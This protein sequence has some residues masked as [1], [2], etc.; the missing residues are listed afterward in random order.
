MSPQ[1]W[2]TNSIP[3]ISKLL[4][5]PWLLISSEL[6]QS[7]VSWKEAGRILFSTLDTVNCRVLS[8]ALFSLP[9][10]LFCVDN[11][12]RIYIL[13]KFMLATHL[14][15]PMANPAMRCVFSTKGILLVTVTVVKWLFFTPEVQFN[16]LKSQTCSMMFCQILLNCLLVSL[17]TGWENIVFLS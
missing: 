7:T 4:R 2:G 17:S 13:I 8:S 12:Q 5:G 6:S 16:P 15:V 10:N 3:P 1:Y 14:A 11:V 9:N